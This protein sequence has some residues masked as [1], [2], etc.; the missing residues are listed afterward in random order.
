MPRRSP[1]IGRTVRAPRPSMGRAPRPPFSD[2]QPVSVRGTCGRSIR[3]PSSLPNPRGSIEAGL[4]PR[5]CIAPTFNAN[6]RVEHH[7]LTVIDQLDENTLLSAAS[8]SAELGA[9]LG[10]VASADKWL[11]SRRGPMTP[12][13]RED[14]TPFDSGNVGGRRRS[15]GGHE[16]PFKLRRRNGEEGSR[17]ARR[18]QNF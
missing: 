17:A 15:A 3:L 5:R 6:H 14:A 16:E 12:A 2:D 7:H 13:N 4:S 10:F 9:A 18:L 1:G 8:R 11:P